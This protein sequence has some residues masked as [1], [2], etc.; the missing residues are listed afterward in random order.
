MTRKLARYLS[1][2]KSLQMLWIA[3]V[4]GKLFT[5]SETSVITHQPALKKRKQKDD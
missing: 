5:M 2:P 3:S 1:A 4:L